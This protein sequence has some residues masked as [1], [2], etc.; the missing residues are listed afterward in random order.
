M[1]LVTLDL[2]HLGG[3]VGR[4]SSPL[5]ADVDAGLRRALDL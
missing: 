3:S 1:Q 4:L 2:A 5:L